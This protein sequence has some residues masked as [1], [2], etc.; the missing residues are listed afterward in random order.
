MGDGHARSPVGA[1]L[2]NA[3]GLGLGFAYLGRLRRAGV[4]VLE[5]GT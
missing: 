2:L 5:A 4:H 1:A 3:S